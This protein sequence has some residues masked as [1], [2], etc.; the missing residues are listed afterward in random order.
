MGKDGGEVIG[1]CQNGHVK[2]ASFAPAVRAAAAEIEVES[3]K[4]VL[5][6]KAGVVIDA[7][8]CAA[9]AVRKND[10][11]TWCSGSRKAQNPVNPAQTSRHTDFDHKITSISCSA[12]RVAFRVYSCGLIS[13][14]GNCFPFR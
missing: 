2:H 9:K 14:C 7:L 12:Q 10:Q 5:D 4:S 8:V 11:G 6:K 13:C 1:F 3:S